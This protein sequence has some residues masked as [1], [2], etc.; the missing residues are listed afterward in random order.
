MSK[1]TEG[2]GRW[3][4]S[5]IVEEAEKEG[6]KEK[7]G[8]KKR[9]RGKMTDRWHKQRIKEG[10]EAQAQMGLGGLFITFMTCVASFGE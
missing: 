10:N 9:K 1:E 6:G 2:G 8:K 4:A 3:L 5:R 7:A